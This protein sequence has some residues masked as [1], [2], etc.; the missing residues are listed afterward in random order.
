MSA[1][2]NKGFSSTCSSSGATTRVCTGL[3]A[4]RSQPRRSS[5]GEA[6]TEP[7][8]TPCWWLI[9]LWVVLRGS[10]YPTIPAQA[11]GSTSSQPLTNPH[12]DEEEGDGEEEE[13]GHHHGRAEAGGHDGQPREEENLLRA[14]EVGDLGVVCGCGRC[15]GAELSWDWVKGLGRRFFSPASTARTSHAPC[16]QTHPYIPWS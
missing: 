14:A 3:D 6:T 15:D 1:R 10:F 7:Q 5:S 2:L 11:S 16:I 9:V 13:R 8:T 12:R 4:R